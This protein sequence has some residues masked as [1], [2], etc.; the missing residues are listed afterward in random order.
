VLLPLYP[1]LQVLPLDSCLHLEILVPHLELG[2]APLLRKMVG[3]DLVVP[4]VAITYC[5]S[6]HYDHWNFILIYTSRSTCFHGEPLVS[7]NTTSLK[8][9]TKPDDLLKILYAFVFES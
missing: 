9:S 7:S 8:T 5:H 2:D 4:A 3:L 6:L 1:F